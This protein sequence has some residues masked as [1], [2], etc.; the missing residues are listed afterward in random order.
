[1]GNAYETFKFQHAGRTFL[2]SLYHDDDGT[3]PWDREDGHGPV[4]QWRQRDSKAPGEVIISEDRRSVRFYDLQAAQRIALRDQWG[5]PE[6]WR[7]AFAAKHGRAPTARE[8]AAESV[9]MDFE[10]LRAWCRDDWHYCG[11]AVQ[12]CDDEGEATGDQFEHA[13]WGIESDSADYLREVAAELAEQIELPPVLGRMWWIADD[14]AEFR[15]DVERLTNAGARV[16]R[17]DSSDAPRIGYV[18][19]LDR[20]KARD[21]VGYEPDAEEWLTED[22][23]SSDN[24]VRDAA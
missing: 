6:A 4:S 13:L 2:A 24:E 22:D 15:A 5:A 19:E 8:C 1:M 12:L 20:A 21:I 18:F 16:V 3:A 7:T 14:D 23:D 11:V 10:R 9:R 17:V